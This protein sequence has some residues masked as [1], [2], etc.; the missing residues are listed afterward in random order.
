[1]VRWSHELIV[2]RAYK[3]PDCRE[4]PE[5][6][7]TLWAQLHCYSA[8]LKS[9]LGVV[10]GGRIRTVS[11]EVCRFCLTLLIRAELLRS[12]LQIPSS[13]AATQHPPTPV[14]CYPRIWFWK[15]AELCGTEPSRVVQSSG[16]SEPKLSLSP[17][18]VQW[19]SSAAQHRWS[20]FHDFVSHCFPLSQAQGWGEPAVRCAHH[21]VFLPRHMELSQSGKYLLCIK[22]HPLLLYAFVINISAVTVHFLLHCCLLSVNSYL[23]QWS[24]P[25]FL[26]CH[27]GWWEEE[28]FI[29]RSNFWLV[30]NHHSSLKQITWSYIPLD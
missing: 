2:L 20:H 24:L 15:A 23:N 13:A 8:P 4:G 14:R 7:A 22:H 12:A 18:L 11:P 25:L 17:S 10:S 5:L 16:R 19:S 6:G 27:R 26:S 30:A 9:R 3:S 28:W 21:L 1:M 29:C